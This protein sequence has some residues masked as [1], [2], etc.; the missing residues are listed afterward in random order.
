LVRTEAVMAAAQGGWLDVSNSESPEF[1]GRVIAA[2]SRDPRLME[3]SGRV[4]VAAQ[5]ARELN[6][7]DTDGKQPAP[8]ALD[9][10]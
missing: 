3:R 2:L 9:A 4:V 8:L 7:F 1:A 5:L 6:V 10:V